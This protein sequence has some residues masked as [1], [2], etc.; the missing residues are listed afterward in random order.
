VFLL[1]LKFVVWARTCPMIIHTANK[2][3]YIFLVVFLLVLSCLLRLVL[4]VLLLVLLL[5]ITEYK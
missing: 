4:I 5:V 2:A 3:T 1:L